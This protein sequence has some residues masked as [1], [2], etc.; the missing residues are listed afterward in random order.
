LHDGSNVGYKAGVVRHKSFAAMQC[1]IARSLDETGDWWS[2]LLLRSAFMGVRRFQDF[3]DRLGIAP[4]TLA[5]RLDHL[6]EHG[7]L[8]RRSYSE[9]PPRDDY[10]LTEKGRDFLPVLLALTAWGNRW[11]APEGAAIECVDPD[12]GARVEPI[13]IDRKSGRELSAG[14]VAVRAGPGALPRLKLALAEPLV[15]GAPGAALEEEI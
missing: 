12:T 1:P 2:M 7:L 4:N 6:V 15:M 5:R 13:V 9:K 3:Q 8:V 11:L 14:N 10:E